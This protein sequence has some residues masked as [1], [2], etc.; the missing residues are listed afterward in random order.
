[1]IHEGILRK[2]YQRVPNLV[3]ER[4]GEQVY[5]TYLQFR[6][7]LLG[8]KVGVVEGK[9]RISYFHI[10]RG[11]TETLVYFHGFADSKD[12]FYDACHFL[13]D[14]YNIIAPDLP[15]FG[16]SDKRKDDTY[17]LDQYAEWMADFLENMEIKACHLVG[18]SLGGAVA[19]AVSLLVPGRITTL[20][21]VDAAGIYHE[22]KHSLHQELFDG[23]IL[24]DVRNRDEFEYLLDRVFYHRPFMPAPVKDFF[25]KEFH[26]HSMWHR[27]V[28]DDLFQ[29]VRSDED[30]RLWNFA[31][32]RQLELIEPPTLILWGD[33]D[34]LFPVETA[35][36]ANSLI[37]R[38]KL[39]FF[40]DVG[41]CPQIEAPR[42]FARVLKKFINDEVRKILQHKLH[43]QKN[44]QHREVISKD[45][46]RQKPELKMVAK[47]TGRS[48]AKPKLAS[49]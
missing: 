11:H 10:D 29:G 48:K 47:K 3:K 42:K 14:R 32:N 38:S 45:V 20:T 33:E 6:R 22:E 21:L 27:K 23:N 49:K 40:T 25:Y 8:A 34:T 18:N 5:D 4:A 30:P 28:L 12:T 2:I 15:G 17:S 1:M 9:R 13:V 43:Q 44:R 46:K 31:L 19:A 36:L 26:R 41:H 37:P 39:H 16:K 7:R 24:F 35:Y